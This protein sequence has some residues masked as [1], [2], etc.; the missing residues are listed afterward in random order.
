MQLRGAISTQKQLRRGV[1]CSPH[2]QRSTAWRNFDPGVDLEDEGLDCLE[3]SLIG[4][5]VVL[6]ECK[7]HSQNL[8]AALQPVI[9]KDRCV[10]CL[11]SAYHRLTAVSTSHEVIYVV[12]A[13]IHPASVSQPRNFF[14]L[15]GFFVSCRSGY[16][17]VALEHPSQLQACCMS[18]C[19]TSTSVA[20][21][22]G[23]HCQM[24]KPYQ[25]AA[26]AYFAILMQRSIRS[27][28][29]ALDV[30]LGSNAI[31]RNSLL[32]FC[33]PAPLTLTECEEK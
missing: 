4:N 10:L 21:M 1:E 12:I 31:V 27:C 5:D 6:A 13:T 15:E 33:I 32:L 11:L 2:A 23:G 28:V 29:L 9:C 26:L 14:K 30:G 8:H 3:D 24:L 16:E 20:R 25:I 19:L 7:R 18:T 17:C 22:V